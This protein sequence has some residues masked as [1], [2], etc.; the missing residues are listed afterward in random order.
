[1]G[2]LDTATNA[3]TQVSR[4]VTSTGPAS[5]LTGIVDNVT[6]FISN[7]G[8]ALSG[9]P[10]PKLPLPNPLHKYASYTY[11]IGFGCLS[12]AEANNPDNSYMK[13]GRIDLLCKSAGADPNN[14]VKTPYG[15]VE[16]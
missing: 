14:R 1:M 4:L 5:G 8:S 12:D 13:G 2:F 11:S 6:G 9:G 10:L 3:V 7:F 16:F 15:S